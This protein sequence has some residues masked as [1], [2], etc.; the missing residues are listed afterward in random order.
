MVRDNRDGIIYGI[1]A[2][3]IPAAA[4]ATLTVSIN[5]VVDSVIGRT[6][7]LKGGRDV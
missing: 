5:L 2:A 6:S 3:L 1:P 4:I 7:S